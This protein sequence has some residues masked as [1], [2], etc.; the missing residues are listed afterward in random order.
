[1]LLT[2]P[3]GCTQLTL[4][5]PPSLRSIE[6]RR[7]SVAICTI[8]SVLSHYST[9][10]RDPSVFFS[11]ANLT[12]NK[13]QCGAILEYLSIREF[14]HS[15]L[16]L[17]EITPKG[18]LVPVTGSLS[19]LYGTYLEDFISVTCHVIGELLDVSIYH[20][21]S[22]YYPSEKGLCSMLNYFVQI[23]AEAQNTFTHR[24]VARNNLNREVLGP[25]RVGDFAYQYRCS[26]DMLSVDT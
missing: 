3:D 23:S 9:E 11:E 24:W 18:L 16:R 22:V 10:D 26:K 13:R 20:S 7:F 19:L 12:T 21:A 6:R 1:M 14:A 5:Y 4:T 8:A 17:P 2:P 15:V 25:F